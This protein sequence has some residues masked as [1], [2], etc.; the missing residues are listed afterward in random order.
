MLSGAVILAAA[1]VIVGATFAFFSD[2]ETSTGNLLAAGEL[3]LKIDSEAHYAG[4][5]CTH[6]DDVNP[7]N[8]V[9]DEPGTIWVDD[10]DQ[11]PT[12]RPDLIGE[13]CTGTWTETDLDESNIFFA[14]SDIKPGD[15]G[16]N[17]ISLHVYDNDAW[18]RMVITTKEDSDNGCTEPESESSDPEC[19]ADI[20]PD[21]APGDGELRESLL[22]TAWLDQGAIEG[23]QCVDANGVLDDDDEDGVCDTDPTEGDNIQQCAT[24]GNPEN[25]D[26]PTVIT[27]GTIDSDPA[28]ETFEFAQGLAAVA[29]AY[30]CEGDGHEDYGECHGLATDGRMVGSTTYY[31][32]VLWTLP[33]SVGNEVQS[34]IFRA[35]VSFQAVQHRN[36]PTPAFPSLTPTP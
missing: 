14:L 19:S 33:G 28:N 17:T 20:P 32:G 15:T 5:V 13:L 12:T 8:G 10:N 3:D 34:D 31:L 27:E 24:P 22:F 18:G 30:G 4:L 2:T 21:P 36:N 11:V 1:A 7:E 6:V 9:E 35:D 23:F 29:E 25:C 16:E 26:E